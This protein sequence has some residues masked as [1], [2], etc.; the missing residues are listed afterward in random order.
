[1]RIYS[2]FGGLKKHAEECAATANAASLPDGWQTLRA[3]G[4]LPARVDF[5]AEEMSYLLSLKNFDLFNKV[6]SLDVVHGSTIG[7]FQLYAAR[8]LALTDMLPASMQGSIGTTTMNSAVFAVFAP[9]AT[10]LDLL[11]SDI[12]ARVD[13]DCKEAREALIETNV[14]VGPT[15]GGPMKLELLR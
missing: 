12:K 14:A 15:L 13:E 5:T 10:E 11:A 9:R 6:L 2:D 3:I 1:M 4:N 8:R 7:I